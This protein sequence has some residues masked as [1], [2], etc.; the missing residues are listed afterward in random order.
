MA[1]VPQPPLSGMD[2]A[3]DYV[4]D[5]VLKSAKYE[6]VGKDYR[7]LIA[8]LHRFKEEMMTFDFVIEVFV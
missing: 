3:T 6:K 4:T 2:L 5:A 7:R 1:I 8:F